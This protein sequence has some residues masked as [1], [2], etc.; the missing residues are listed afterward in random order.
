MLDQA[1][2]KSI[3]DRNQAN[4]GRQ[5]PVISCKDRKLTSLFQLKP[6]P[7]AGHE[8]HLKPVDAFESEE[9]S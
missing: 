2:A 8:W 6:G 4:V 1:L 9:W 3:Q 7:I 5:H